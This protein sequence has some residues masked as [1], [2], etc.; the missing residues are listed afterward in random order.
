MNIQWTYKDYVTKGP[1]V[2]GVLNFAQVTKT[3]NR[4][5]Y[6]DEWATLPMELAK[7]VPSYASFVSASKNAMIDH[8]QIESGSGSTAVK[9]RVPDN[10]MKVAPKT[11]TETVQWVQFYNHA[12]LTTNAYVIA[13]VELN[14]I[15]SWS[16]V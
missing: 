10:I 16:S 13:E 6:R 11:K 1:I 15:V 3:Q 4:G 14:E 5:T 9:W 2:E 8:D 12:S 7:A